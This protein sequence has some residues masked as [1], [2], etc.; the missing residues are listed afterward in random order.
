MQSSRNLWRSFLNTLSSQSKLSRRPIRRSKR[1]AVDL[2]A[3]QPLESRTLLTTTLFSDNF[4][5]GSVSTSLWPSAGPAEA[6]AFALSESSTYGPIGAGGSWAAAIYGTGSYSGFDISSRGM[7]SKSLNLAGYNWVQ[8][9]L[10]VEAEGK[11][12][13]PESDEDLIIRYRNSS[14]TWVTLANIDQSTVGHSSFTSKSYMLP[15]NALHSTF[16]F[17]IYATGLDYTGSYFFGYD[18]ADHWYVDNVSVI[19][20]RAPSISATIPQNMNDGSESTLSWSAS[21]PDSDSISSLSAQL[22]RGSTVVR[23]SSTGSLKI[24]PADGPGSYT[25]V[26]SA[27]DNTGASASKSFAFTHSDDDVQAPVISL[28]TVAGGSPQTDDKDQVFTWNISDSGSG[29]ASREVTIARFD[30]LAGYFVRVHVDSTNNSGQFDFN[31]LGPGT[32]SIQAVATDLDNDR[33]G[34]ASAASNSMTVIVGDDDASPPE[35][36]ITGSQGEE[37]AQLDQRFTWYVSDQSDSTTQVVIRKNGVPIL[38]REYDADVEYDTFDF[39]SLGVG[40]YSITVTSTDKD[41]D[42]AADKLS[43]T[44]T[45]T[46]NVVYPT[47][48][49]VLSV[50]TPEADRREGSP[51]S[52]DS[53]GS[54]DPN[55]GA[56]TFH[57]DFGDGQTSTAPSPVHVYPDSGVYTVTLSVLDPYGGVGLTQT[58]VAVGNVAPTAQWSGEAI[59]FEGSVASLSLTGVSDPSLAD[60][61]AGFRYSFDFD[62]DG[63]WDVGNGTWA[64]AVTAALVTVPATKLPTLGS[65]SLRGRVLDKDGGYT[66]SVETLI[67]AD[68]D[69]DVPLIELK[70]RS[71]VT[72]DAPGTWNWLISDVSGI[73]EFSIEV[74]HDSGNGPVTIFSSSDSADLQG[75]IDLSPLGVGEFA[76]TVTATDADA[77]RSGDSLSATAT[78]TIRVVEPG[79]NTAP[80]AQDAEFTLTSNG[81][82][83]VTLNSGDAESPAELMTFTIQSLPANGDL[84]APDGSVVRIGDQ[85]TG[86]PATLTYRVRYAVGDMTDSFQFTVTDSGN[87]SITVSNALTSLPGTMTVRTPAGSAGI[88]RIGGTTGSDTIALEETDS[89]S[90]FTFSFNG[91]ILGAPQPSESVEEVLV[92]GHEGDDSF[93]FG[94]TS[95]QISMDGGSGLNSVTFDNPWVEGVGFDGVDGLTFDGVQMGSFSSITGV[96]LSAV[97]GTKAKVVAGQLQVSGSSLSNDDIRLRQFTPS[98]KTNSIVEVYDGN[99]LLGSYRA[100]ELTSIRVTGSDGNDRIDLAWDPNAVVQ[101]RAELDGGNGNDTLIGGDG[102]DILR[103]GTGKNQLHG[104]HGTDELFDQDRAV[105]RPT[106]LVVV[107]GFE[108]YRGEALGT[109]DETGE[110]DWS[111][112][113]ARKVAMALE[114]AGTPTTTLLID[115]NSTNGSNV[116]PSERVADKVMEFINSQNEVWDVFFFGHSRGGV[117]VREVGNKLEDS[118]NLGQVRQIM[119]DPTAADLMADR[120]G[121]VSSLVDATTYDDEFVLTSFGVTDGIIVNRGGEY[122]PVQTEMRDNPTGG[123]I[124]FE[125]SFAVA[126]GLGTGIDTWMF[127]LF[128]QGTYGNVIRVVKAV[129]EHV[130]YHVEITPWYLE[131]SDFFSQ[132]ITSF[133]SGKGSAD[134]YTTWVNPVSEWT[135]DEHYTIFNAGQAEYDT[136]WRDVLTSV[137]NHYRYF[138]SLSLTIGQNVVDVVL[139]LLSYLGEPSE[140]DDY[141]EQ[142][143]KENFRLAIGGIQRFSDLAFTVARH[144]GDYGT[145]IVNRAMIRTLDVVLDGMLR[146]ARD[147][148]QSFEDFSAGFIDVTNQIREGLQDGIKQLLGPFASLLPRLDVRITDDGVKL[149]GELKSEFLPNSV[150][151]T[152]EFNTDGSISISG[153]AE[154]PAVGGEVALTGTITRFGKYSLSGNL[155]GKS[156]SLG[157]FVGGSVN[158]SNTGISISGLAELPV[159][160]KAQLEGSISSK[161]KYSLT[162]QNVPATIHGFQLPGVS[163]TL[164]NDGLFVSGDAKLSFL[165]TVFVSGSVTSSAKYS[166]TA[167]NQSRTI[168]GYSFPS[169]AITLSNTGLSVAGS[170]SLPLIG[171][172]SLAGA[173]TS[174]GQYLLAARNVAKTIKGFSFPSLTVKLS[175]SGIELSGSSS[176]P[177]IGSTTLTGYVDSAGNFTLEQTVTGRKIGGFSFPS[178]LVRLTNNGLLVSGSATVPLIGKLQLT[179]SIVSSRNFELSGE[180]TG[181]RIDEYALPTLSVT[182][183]PDGLEISGKAD[184]PVLGRINVSGRVYTSGAFV[185]TANNIPK[186][187]AGFHLP[188]LSVRISNSGIRVSGQATISV[189]GTAQFSGTIEANGNFRLTA[190]LYNDLAGVQ[191]GSVILA[192]NGLEVRAWIPLIGNVSMELSAGRLKVSPNFNL[193]VFKIKHIYLYASGKFRV[194]GW[195]SVLGDFSVTGPDISKIKELMENLL[196]K[197]K[198]DGPRVGGVAGKAGNAI[199]TGWKSARKFNGT[200]AGALVFFDAN[201]NGVLDDLTDDP[202]AGGYSEPWTFTNY[203]GEFVPEVSADF[204]RNGNGILDNEDGQWVVLGGQF[205]ATGLD[206]QTVTMSPASWAMMTPLTTLVS[207]YSSRHGVSVADASTRISAAFGLPEIDL[208]V[209][210]PISIMRSGN[211]VGGD[212]YLTHA[213]LTDTASQI[214]ALFPTSETLTG[215]DLSRA[216]NQ[217]MVDQIAASSGQYDLHDPETVESLIRNV[218][219]LVGTPLSDE[220]VAGAA[221]V[222]TSINGRFGDIDPQTGIAVM[223]SAE[224]IKLV[225][226]GA[227]VTALKEAAGGQ[228]TIAEVVSQFTGDALTARILAAVIPPS[229]LV[230]ESI[231]V[232]AGSAAGAIAEFLVTATDISGQSLPTVL[233]HASGTL[234][235]LGTT[236]VTA[237]TIDTFGVMTAK[238]FMVTVVDTIAPALTITETLQFEATGPDGIDISVLNAAVTDAVDDA[239]LVTFS[240]VDGKLPIGVQKFVD[241]LLP[242]QRAHFFGSGQHL[243]R[244]AAGFVRPPPQPCIAI[245]ALGTQNLDAKAQRVPE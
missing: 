38:S 109:G 127:G 164:S 48:V 99:R 125:D 14:G 139:N 152:G 215:Q 199:S 44:A 93:S 27:S 108:T 71:G 96:S 173:I 241:A 174:K 70:G 236:T 184:V 143:A 10:S 219:S 224:P 140:N 5:S 92:Y 45:R 41:T 91:E 59:V 117:F 53:T 208:A 13:S 123:L 94:T 144:L 231:T 160:G 209:F 213:I 18:P 34:D 82:A 86:S 198:I 177:I 39:N 161:G 196:P 171:S 107:H 88:V 165:G 60:T 62:N 234:F 23:S 80:T 214:M 4:E 66:D 68:D 11:G 58:S 167:A 69:T 181:R 102:P 74:T 132:D 130:M 116:G 153:E 141:G 175:N 112:N 77:D 49:A 187:F 239:P 197:V 137:V 150:A 104:G 25:L 176:L 243:S 237:S 210:E 65:Y 200:T 114:A 42:Y 24:T 33:N 158:I 12:N 147:N 55:G 110:G 216:V 122:I 61:A 76:V 78:R 183:S 188:S 52:F 113:Y 156:V 56:I 87:P 203:L 149:E 201:F 134:N 111:Q 138:G 195:T 98:G 37:S 8:L 182:L 223:N 1:R 155:N 19:G 83:V 47:P 157:A 54:V 133:V 189:I 90:A 89:G 85:F 205:T 16:A 129:A 30:D 162:A 166:L 2:S 32:Y 226:Q 36:S 178:L 225:A 50:L 212:V 245:A 193:G 103:G 233:S 159:I 220:L 148:E 28:G 106:L 21:D 228:R 79:P 244:D 15:A 51:I 118:P 180:F 120:S 185:L 151:V 179:G 72:A 207:G 242:P 95:L 35:I 97:L 222:V 235:P 17:Q 67:V 115:W 227:A 204:D 121:N 230:P 124:A 3:T 229:L 190:S 142:R 232:E 46:V 169:L 29:V 20:S 163:V 105:L 238:S 146:V 217:V 202:D 7:E 145:D 73:A 84:I 170:S 75:S 31:H 40:T 192:N 206:I 240:I 126:S 101:I 26:V 211:A 168:A 81:T 194:T 172:V 218:A 136:N 64:G 43:A 186:S 57:W 119:L 22:K 221:T 131:K 63:V 135:K 191:L 9:N 128:G 6:R 100:S 154:V